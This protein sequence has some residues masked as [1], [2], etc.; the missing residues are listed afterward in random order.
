MKI[1]GQDEKAQP[2]PQAVAGLG[3]TPEQLKEWLDMLKSAAGLV[4]G[5]AT[6][7]YF[8]GFIVTSTRLLNYGISDFSLLQARYVATGILFVSLAALSIYPAYFSAQVFARWLAGHGW[9]LVGGKSSPSPLVLKIPVSQSAL[10]TKM[11][12]DLSVKPGGLVSSA[13]NTPLPS[14]GQPQAPAAEEKSQE[15]PITVN[16]SLV[17]PTVAEL[18]K[19][20]PITPHSMPVQGMIYL[21]QDTS[22]SSIVLDAL[23]ENL[24]LMGTWYGLLGLLLVTNLIALAIFTFISMPT[25]LGHQTLSAGVFAQAMWDNFQGAQGWYWL[26]L[27]FG[28]ILALVLRGVPESLRLVGIPNA[29]WGVAALLIL[30]VFMIPLYT[31]QI[32]P[33][34]APSLGG[35]RT[36]PVQL[37]A[38]SASAPTLAQLVPVQPDAPVK[39]VK[40][41]LLDE[42]DK[43]FFLLVPGPSAGQVYAV[44]IDKALVKGVVFLES[45]R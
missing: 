25:W 30:L 3:K 23:P 39:T 45:G 5:L 21:D 16:T 26:C 28:L 31:Q 18:L 12:A 29:F 37:V 10:A 2:K 4:A 40:V 13:L 36:I 17:N 1:L 11:A 6:V 14:A 41:D 8:F 35:G 15:V 32:Y 34:V 33:S 9:W 22:I 19:S 7:F 44:R 24:R 43:A 27:L 38:D 42:N 20:T